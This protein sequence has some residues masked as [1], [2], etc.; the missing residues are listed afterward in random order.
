M[1]ISESRERD[2]VCAMV[3]GESVVEKWLRKGDVCLD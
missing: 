2:I 1:L 3:V